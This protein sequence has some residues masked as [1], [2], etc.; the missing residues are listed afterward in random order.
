[1]SPTSSGDAVP[2][3][4]V[5][6]VRGGRARRSC[7]PAVQAAADGRYRLPGVADGRYRVRAVAP[8]GVNLVAQYAPGTGSTGRRA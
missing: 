3:A 2:G 7:S 5:D 6:A 1:M 8:V 4:W